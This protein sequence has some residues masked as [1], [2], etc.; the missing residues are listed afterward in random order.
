MKL[1][2]F[3]HNGSESVG[4]LAGDRVVDLFSG[5]M[6]ARP[7]MIALLEGGPSALAEVRKIV[8]RALVGNGSS[9]LSH[10][11]G[12]VRL[13]APVPRPGKIICIGLNY[14]D[15][16]EEVGMKIP[17]RP[18]LFSKYASAVVGPDEK[19]VIPAVTQEADYEAELAVVI[20]RKA[21]GVGEAEALDYVAGYTMVND[22]SARDLQLRLGGGQWLWGKTLDTFAPM[23]PTLVTSDEVPDPSDLDIA[24]RLNG[25]TMQ[26]SNTRNL[27]FGVQALIAFI[28][29]AITLEP[30]DVISTGTPGGVGFNRK[31]PVYLKAGDVMEVEV[32]G[33]GVLRN[34]VVREG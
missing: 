5:S 32:E 8:D 27:I 12:E 25:Q 17:E 23:G 30:G 33:L 4:A 26:D 28:S 3:M 18:I 7:D 19:V 22:V 11:L 31:P 13:L 34:Q 29:Q 1:V 16:A 9:S 2:T 24:F 14:R 20:G 15:H 10:P 21:R 6:S